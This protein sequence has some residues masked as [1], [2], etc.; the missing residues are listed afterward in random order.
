MTT[1]GEEFLGISGSDNS[2]PSSQGAQRTPPK[3]GW[4]VVFYVF[5]GLLLL[6]TGITLLRFFGDWLEYS[7]PDPELGLPCL[8]WIAGTLQVFFAGFLVN[9]FTDIRWYLRTLAERDKE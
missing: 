4:S 9:V 2:N 8:Y 7:E 6:L 3:S 5:G 1:E